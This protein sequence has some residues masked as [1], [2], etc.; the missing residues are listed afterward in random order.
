[1]RY[2]LD[3]KKSQLN[4]WESMIFDHLKGQKRLE[5]LFHGGI[6]VRILIHAVRVLGI[7]N[8]QPIR[9]SG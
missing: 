6:R 9:D 2:M 7:R 5:L 1:M 8:T 4:S 3:L